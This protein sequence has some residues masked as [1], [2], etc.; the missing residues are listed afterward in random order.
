[1]NID[2]NRCRKRSYHWLRLQGAVLTKDWLFATAGTGITTKRT[3]MN[4]CE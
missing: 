4:S 2:V 1:M 3:G